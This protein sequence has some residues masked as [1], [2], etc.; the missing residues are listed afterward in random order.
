MVDGIAA[1]VLLSKD[2]S[3]IA[4]NTEVQKFSDLLWGM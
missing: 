1:A 2:I 3:N 4:S